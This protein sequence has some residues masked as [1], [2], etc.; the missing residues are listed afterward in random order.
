MPFQ[1]ITLILLMLN[2]PNSDAEVF[3]FQMQMLCLIN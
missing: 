3:N 1:T 2:F